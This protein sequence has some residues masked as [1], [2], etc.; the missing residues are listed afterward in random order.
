MGEEGATAQAA[1]APARPE[2]ADRG[3]V[4]RRRSA[5]WAILLVGLSFAMVIQNWSDNQSS[6]YDLIRALAA[7]RTTIDYGPYSTKDK[8]CYPQK[9]KGETGCAYGHWYSARA[10]GLAMYS[11]PFYEVLEAIDAPAVARA[12]QALRN[13]DE[14]IYFV[15]LW[16]SVLPGLILLLLIW[17]VAERFEP[18]Y[19]GPTAVIVGL[20]TIV[21]PFSTLLFSHVFSAMLGFACFAV[22]VHERHGQP[23]PLLLAAAGLLIGYGIT[24]EYPVAFSAVVLGL[25]MLSRPDSLRPGPL[26]LRAATFVGGAVVGLIPLLLYNHA[27]FNSW[28]H[29]AYSNIPQQQKGFF[30]ISAP[31]IPVLGTLLLDSRGLLTL[32]PVLIMGAVGTVLLYRRGARAEALAV[33]GVCVLYLGYNAGYYLPFGGGSVGPRFLIT[34]VPY[35]GFPI[36]LALRRFRAQTIAL[37]GASVAVA[38]IA[39]MTHPLVG[40]ENETVVWTRLLGQGSF[41]P[42]IASAFGAGRGFGAA[43]PFLLVVLA[44]LGFAVRALPRQS[45]GL[46]SLGWGA[47]CV[48]S[49]AIFAAVGPTVLRLDH[50][51]LQSILGAGDKTALN[52]T[53]HSGATY[54]LKTLALIGF[55]VGLLGMLAVALLRDRRPPRG[56][57]APAAAEPRAALG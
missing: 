24:S 10:P 16:G 7:G 8:A 26:V 45:I 46:S 40:Y 52:L 14:M 1:E 12:S 57:R 4:R 27:A 13:E 30:G 38:V 19:G 9:V 5:L 32:F 22:L 47:L 2:R 51:G 44:A 36:A 25:Y 55:G 48:G 41:Q 39:T 43:L 28:T 49:W 21:L 6:H 17:R 11:L 20:G 3:A 29:L 37:A 23:R 54:P 35:L 15:G 56:Q 50:R 33:T 18:G 53:L 34:I 42:T 31:S